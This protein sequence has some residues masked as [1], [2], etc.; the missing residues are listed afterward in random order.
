M[1]PEGR[2]LGGASPCQLCGALQGEGPAEHQFASWMGSL[3]K[4]PVIEAF[5]SREGLY[6]FDLPCPRWVIFSHLRGGTWWCKICF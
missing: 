2:A 6:C 4:N 5:G 3:T 1:V